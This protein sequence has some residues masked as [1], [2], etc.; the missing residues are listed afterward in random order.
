MVGWDFCQGVLQ[1]F[2]RGESSYDLL[3]YEDNVFRDLYNLRLYTEASFMWGFEL[4]FNEENGDAED[5]KDEETNENNDNENETEEEG[6]TGE[7]GRPDWGGEV[8]A[9]EGGRGDIGGKGGGDLVGGWIAVD[10]A[11][12]TV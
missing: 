11:S 8:V 6:E 7:V 1:R 9:I 10:N 4:L 3:N 5:D 12:H 2:Y